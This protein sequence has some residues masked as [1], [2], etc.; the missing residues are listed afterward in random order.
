[1]L[2]RNKAVR[3]TSFNVTFLRTLVDLLEKFSIVKWCAM[4]IQIRKIRAVGMM[5]LVMAFQNIQNF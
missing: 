1:M 3:R 2:A 4:M 5:K